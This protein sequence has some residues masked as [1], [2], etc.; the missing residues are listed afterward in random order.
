MQKKKKKKLQASKELAL[1]V[2]I[3]CSMSAQYAMRNPLYK[4]KFLHEIPPVMTVPS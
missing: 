1:S 4:T 3:I 2:I